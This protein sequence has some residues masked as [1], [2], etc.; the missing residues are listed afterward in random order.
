[1]IIEFDPCENLCHQFNNEKC[2]TCNREKP[3][4]KKL[5]NLC[6]CSRDGTKDHR[7][8]CE[9]GHGAKLEGYKI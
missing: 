5:N 7:S 6:P 9:E 1:M 4:W 2:L 8:Y 3:L